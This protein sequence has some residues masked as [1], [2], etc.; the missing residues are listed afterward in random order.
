ME[1]ASDKTMEQ[2]EQQSG[3]KRASWL[4]QVMKFV[5]PLGVTVGLCWPMFHS[6]DFNEMIAI[7]HDQCNFW[8]IGF[9][10]GLSFFSNFFRAWRWGIQLD[11]LGYRVPRHILVYSIFGTYAINLIFPRLGEFWRTGYV[12]QRQKAPFATVFGSMV[13]ERLSD[14]VVVFL[15]LVFTCLVAYQHIAAYLGQNE[16][17]YEQAVN[18]VTSPWLWLVI[19]LCLAFAWW[20][21]TRRSTPGSIFAKAQKFVRGLWKGFSSIA[22]MPHKGRWLFFTFCLWTCY[23]TQM[24]VAFQ[25]FP[26]T[27]EAFAQHGLV[28]PLLTFV[29]TSVAMGVP[30]NG[31][32]GPW[33]W[34]CIFALSIYSIGAVDASAFANLVL[35]CNTVL[36]IVL[37]IVTFIAVMVDRRK[38][39][40]LQVANEK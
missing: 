26:F 28:A 1:A 12:A 10:L 40:K 29:L 3:K 30:S 7:I 5:I 4:G 31:G 6:I 9:G 13:A 11:A 36:L 2:Q 14:T 18:A 19:A 20:F 37:G 32:I 27:R 38:N 15:I 23:F 8:W 39:D 35:G 34:A 25:A 16:A 21:L 33:Q 17:L 22:T 24:V